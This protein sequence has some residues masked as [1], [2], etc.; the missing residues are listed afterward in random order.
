MGSNSTAPRRNAADEEAQLRDALAQSEE[1]LQCVIELS[2]DYYWETDEHHRFTL[3]RHQAAGGPATD[4]RRFLGKATWELG[5]EPIEGSWEEYRAAR[6]AG[7]PFKDF[8]VRRPDANGRDLYLSATG[9]PIIDSAGRFKGYRGI[10]RDVTALVREERLRRLDRTIAGILP[11]AANVG[12]GLTAAIR[13]I[14][15]SEGWESGQYWSVDEARGVMHLYAGW[16]VTDAAIRR[17]A[18][19]ARELTFAPG[20]GLV[21]VV[22][23]TA[24]PLWIADLRRE[25]RL[26]RKD[27]AR[28]TG[29]DNAFLF[30]VLSDSRPIGVLDF[31]ARR[32]PEPDERLLEVI[33]VLGTQI[34]AFYE[35]AV[36]LEKLR[37][38]EERYSS[39]VELA[40]IGISHVSADGRFIHVNRRLCEMLGY[41]REEMLALGVKEISH[42]D[43]AS[44]T[45]VDKRKLHRG[46]IDTLE[47]EKRYLRK[48]GTPVWVRINV[49]VNRAP[50]GEPLYDISVVE[51]I[52]ERKRAEE[53]VQYLATHDE[54][55]GLPNRAMFSQLLNHAIESARRSAGKLAVLFLDLDRFKIINDSLGHEAGDELLK[56]VAARLKTCLRASDVLARLGGD[57]FV[58]LV[59]SLK[60]PRQAARV[61]RNLLSA[62]LKPVEI[63]GHEC[64]VTASV[65]ISMFPAD[66]ADAQSLMKNAD[67]AMYAAKEEGKNNYQFYSKGGGS[68]SIERLTLETSLRRALER[69]ELKLQYQ[70]KVAVGTGEITGAEALLRWWN[71]EL[72]TVPPAQF[73]PLAEDTGL[74]VPIGK[75][76]LATACAQNVAW[77]R[78]GL[79]SIRMA[80][81]ISPRQFKDPNLLRD[82][83]A[84]L[85]ASGMAPELLELEITEGVIMHD[86]DR[87]LKKLNAIKSMGVR[88]AI[89][90]FGTG[91]SSLAQLK[92]LPIDTLK[93]DRSFIREIPKDPEDKAITEAIIAMGKTLGVTVVAEGVESAEQQAFL[94]SRA[95]D[96]LQGYYFSK[97]CHPDALADLLETYLPA[98]LA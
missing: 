70:A 4:P 2:S 8:V 26:L 14:C 48:D 44:L 17:V 64:R 77:Q 23:Q 74:I 53:R 30:P 83:A 76:V 12:E 35:R 39:T 27:I 95:C 49:A 13:A 16:S 6:A 32:I 92:R 20:S 72:G 63:L 88:L 86:V 57:E 82:V 43:D 19:E 60:E 84:A 10:T 51:D 1:R 46:E 79:P 73:I 89:D 45:D 61:A 40:A 96:E 52:S 97:P 15:E 69:R 54:M 41:T 3:V 78:D 68:L 93:V 56:K 55:T 91:Y 24:K 9:R 81:N 98:R 65:G 59:E 58:V 34:G 50:D 11:D 38:S 7:E 87:A 71:R 33:H 18:E 85:E 29:W 75:W 37:A 67:V 21:G 90:D 66:A 28:Q 94:T 5:V 42:P 62:A 22:W 25:R 31:N 47:V 36:A 80:V